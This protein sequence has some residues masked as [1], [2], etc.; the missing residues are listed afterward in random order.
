MKKFLIGIIVVAV[1]VAYILYEKN[2][3]NMII[4]KG[5]STTTESTATTT[6]NS[7][8]DGTYDGPLTDAYFGPMQVQ[9]TI[10]S[11]KISDIKF[12][13]YP[14]HSGHTNDLSVATLPVLKQEAIQS[15]G[16]IGVQIISGA[17]Q[18]SE[19]FKQSLEGAIA[20]AK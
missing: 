3:Q 13:Q 4:T 16:T 20:L 15:Q 8:K 1:F 17:T 7:L 5:T 14:T 11:G 6:Q 19:A 2:N 12:L 18:T 9:I 10:Q